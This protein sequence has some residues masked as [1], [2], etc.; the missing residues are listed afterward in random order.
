MWSTQLVMPA[1]PAPG[2][3]RRKYNFTFENLEGQDEV[4]LAVPAF[5][6]EEV[7]LVKTFLLWNSMETSL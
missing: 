1:Q 6:R 3:C 4:S 5:L 7:E 2:E